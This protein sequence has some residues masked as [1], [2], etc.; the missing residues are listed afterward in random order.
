MDLLIP[1]SIVII[2]MVAIGGVWGWTIISELMKARTL[3]LQTPP[4][5]PR[6]GELLEDFR[7][8]EARLDKLEEE[9]GFFRALHAP[10]ESPSLPPP[11]DEAP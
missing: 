6:I 11:D 3:K 8:L 4:G 2:L 1:L 5:D 9:V 10:E 7:L